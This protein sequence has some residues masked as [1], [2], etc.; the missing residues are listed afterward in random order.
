MSLPTAGDVLFERRVEYS[1]RQRRLRAAAPVAITAQLGWPAFWSAIDSAL[2]SCGYSRGTRL[3]YRQVL[4][5]LCGAGMR[6]PAE[7]TASRV[8]D[9]LHRIRESECSASWLALNITALRVIFDRLCGQC[10]TAS[11][12]TPKRPLKLP[13]ILSEPEAE[14]LVRAAQNIRD[15]LLLGLLYGCGLT[16]RE[17]ACL[18]WGDVRSG[19][20]KLHIAASTRYLERV[21]Q[22]PDAFR[23]ILR[24]GQDTCG[25]RDPVFRGRT[26]GKPIST[27]MIEVLV[28]KAR[29]TAG[30]GRPVCV[31]TLRHS[32]AVQRLEAGIGL[33]QVQEELGHASIRTTERYVRCLAPKLERHPFSRVSKLAGKYNSAA[34]PRLDRSDAPKSSAPAQ[35]EPRGLLSRC[36]PTAF[37]RGRRPGSGARP[38]ASLESVHMRRLTLPLPP[39]ESP[40]PAE[41]FFRLLKSRLLVGILVKRPR[42]SP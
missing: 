20:R 29:E 4:R 33:R 30:I 12:V 3:Q 36:L 26:P 9:F 41:A 21:V 18:R 24:T 19:G 39:I 16:G 10:V 32:Y 8:R 17:A 15:Q 25:P 7:V 14:R 40:G 35:P 6:R 13:E 42:G 1:Q 22:V 2:R 37:G 23:E 27:R 31:M 11:C 38:L 5:A 34:G 28:R